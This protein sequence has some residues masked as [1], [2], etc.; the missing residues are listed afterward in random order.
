MKKKKKNENSSKIFEHHDHEACFGDAITLIEDCFIEKKLQLTPLRRKVFEILIEDHK[1]LG[2]Y[3]ILDKLGEAGFSS[4]PPIAY[5]V[6]DFLI[7]HGFVHKVQGLNAFIACSNPK[8][9]H[10]P[11]FVI[12]R[13]CEK[14]AEVS[15]EK[16]RLNLSSPEITDFKIEKTTIE[17]TGVCSTCENAEIR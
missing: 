2:A 8:Q 4:S 12:C 7:E 16:T 9:S 1:P 17:L 11:T 6:L 13:K 10:F 3:D 15:D 14:V 5:R